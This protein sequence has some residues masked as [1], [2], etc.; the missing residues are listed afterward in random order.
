METF[1]QQKGF[2]DHIKYEDFQAFFDDRKKVPREERFF[3]ALRSIYAQDLSESDEDSAIAE[4]EKHYPDSAPWLA[5]KV[6]LENQWI[7]DEIKIRGLFQGTIEE[8]LWI[9]LSNI[10]NIY[11][12][13][14]Q[15]RVVTQTEEAGNFMYLLTQFFN[16]TF[17]EKKDTLLS[18]TASIQSIAEKLLDLGDAPDFQEMICFKI[19]SAMPYKYD[20]IQQRLFQM[21]RSKLTID[22]IKSKFAT[23]DSR[24]KANRLINNSNFNNGNNNYNTNNCNRINV[25]NQK[26]EE[27]NAVTERK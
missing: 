16:R 26:K 1:I 15:I 2:S 12:L 3:K 4:L 10:N 24:A 19:L 23:E 27:S 6:K 7:Q 25:N 22:R 8:N 18:Y 20:Q 17:D 13:W 5:N 21:P 14:S 11:D 9:S